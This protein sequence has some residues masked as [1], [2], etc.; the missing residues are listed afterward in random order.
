[1]LKIWFT[2][3]ILSL[4]NILCSASQYKVVCITE[5]GGSECFQVYILGTGIWMRVETGVASGF[6][7]CYLVQHAACNGNLHRTVDVLDR[8]CFRICGFDVETEY[9]SIF[10]PPAPLTLL[11]DRVDDLHLVFNVVSDFL[12][13]C[14]TVDYEIIIW[15]MKEYRVEESWSIEYKLSTIGFDIDG[16]WVNN[17]ACRIKM[18]KDG[19][20]LMILDGEDLIYYSNKTRSTQHIGMFNDANEGYYVNVATIFTP[21]LFKLESFG[22]ESV[23][24]FQIIILV[25]I[26]VLVVIWPYLHYVIMIHLFSHLTSSINSLSHLLVTTY[27]LS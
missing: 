8:P 16:G 20:V 19:D 18:F 2:Y 26:F 24:S 22:L 10:S 3:A 4:V 27:I 14:Y 15:L 11:D 7:F 23:I 17:F 12:C 5:V 1:M 25:Y 21:S 9:F 6:T 13:F